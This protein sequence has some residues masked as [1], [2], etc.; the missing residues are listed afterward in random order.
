MGADARNSG[1]VHLSVRVTHVGRGQGRTKSRVVWLSESRTDKL[2]FLAERETENGEHALEL[3][4]GV[5]D[6]M[7]QL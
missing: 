1:S 2:E 5:T 3:V 7:N 6:T 4:V